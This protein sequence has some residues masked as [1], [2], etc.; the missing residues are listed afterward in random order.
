MTTIKVTQ[1]VWLYMNPGLSPLNDSKRYFPILNDR[2]FWRKLGLKSGIDMWH[3]GTEY[4]PFKFETFHLNVYSSTDLL[5]GSCQESLAE[6][7]MKCL[8]GSN[9]LTEILKHIFIYFHRL[10]YV[11][12]WH[13]IHFTTGIGHSML[14]W[15]LLTVEL[16]G[17]IWTDR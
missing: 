6:S 11:W 7:K 15:N 10:C 8:K 9:T 4:R 14:Q 17:S 5:K 16:N 1:L 2:I 12:N 13:K 3:Y